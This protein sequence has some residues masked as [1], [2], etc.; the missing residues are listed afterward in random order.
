MV[1]LFL[2]QLGFILFSLHSQEAF[3]SFSLQEKISES[4]FIS[5]NQS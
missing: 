1:G 3:F 2:F 4:L 5:S